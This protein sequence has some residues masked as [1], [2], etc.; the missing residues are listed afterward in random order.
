MLLLNDKRDAR[1][2][3]RSLNIIRCPCYGYLTI[4]ERFY[5]VPGDLRKSSIASNRLYR[6]LLIFL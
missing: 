4:V 5:R 3:N 6:I 2:S 1:N